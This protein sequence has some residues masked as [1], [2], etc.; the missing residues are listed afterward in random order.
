[1]NRL[2]LC[3]AA[4]LLVAACAQSSKQ[5][6]FTTPDEK[7][8]ARQDVVVQ[9]DNASVF[10]SDARLKAGGSVT[11][12]NTSDQMAVVRFP[13]V[14]KTKFT[15]R[16]VLRPDWQY[17]ADALESIPTG[18][19]TDRIVFPCSLQPGKY[20]YTISL[21][22]RIADMDNPAFTLSATLIVE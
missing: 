7:Q 19:A 11:W 6:S 17:A 10:P 9:F 21:F 5:Q 15:C 20:P 2:A 12:N 18:G 3:L 1:M 4:V 14:D 16:P 22:G 8:P 13:K